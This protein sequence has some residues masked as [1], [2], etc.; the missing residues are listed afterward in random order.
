MGNGVKVK[1]KAP[2]SLVREADN[3]KTHQQDN[4]RRAA[5]VL[6]ASSSRTFAAGFST[7]PTLRRLLRIH[8]A[9][10]SS[11]HDELLGIVA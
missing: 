11:A 7:M 9:V 6:T 1:Q 10:P 2:R 5:F 3:A 8:R 4:I